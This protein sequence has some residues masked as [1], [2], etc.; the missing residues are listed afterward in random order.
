[1]IARV[2]DGIVSAWRLADSWGEFLFTVTL[3][4]GSC[5]W[6]AGSL[7]AGHFLNWAEFIAFRDAAFGWVTAGGR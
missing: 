2:W 1:M 7:H 3:A 6:L 4:A 5:L